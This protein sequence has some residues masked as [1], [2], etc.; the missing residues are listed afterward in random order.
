MLYICTKHISHATTLL[1][2]EP[3]SG[4]LPK[5]TT[6]TKTTIKQRIETTTKKCG[7]AGPDGSEKVDCKDTLADSYIEEYYSEEYGTQD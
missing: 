4:R 6:T 5:A 3:Q 7:F 1:W 2:L